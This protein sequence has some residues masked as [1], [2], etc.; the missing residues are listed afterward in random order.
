MTAAEAETAAPGGLS[1]GLFA[2]IGAALGRLTGVL[3]R[4]EQAADRVWQDLH[5]V[6]IARQMLVTAGSVVDVPDLL[7]PHDGLWWDVRRL[8]FMGAIGTGSVDVH[9][10]DVNSEIVARVSSLP[11]ILTWSS[12]V[13]LGPRDR[14]VY[15]ANTGVTGPVYISGQA[16]EIAGQ[17]LPA[18]LM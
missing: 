15:Q 16:F 5:P 10:N 12:Q 14:L 9:I 11:S 1:V 18:Y 3:E 8:S 4:R 17:L 2:E 6:P 13:I 7:G